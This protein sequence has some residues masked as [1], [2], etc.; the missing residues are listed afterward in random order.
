MLLVLRGQALPVLHVLMIS[1]ASW[2]I[3]GLN[4]A[5][6]QNEVQ[7]VIN[8]NKLCICAILESHVHISN[9]ER[10]CSRVF[11][12]WSWTSNSSRSAIGSRIILGWD[13][14]RV[15]LMVLSFSDQVMHCQVW[16]RDC[17]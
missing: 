17:N 9:L 13:P 14:D 4:R 11:R 5:P 7:Q 1:L 12:R 2:N 15:D 6:K 16:V 3:R 8:E 10:I